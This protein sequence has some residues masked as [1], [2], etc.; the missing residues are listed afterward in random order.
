LVAAWREALSGHS[1]SRIGIAWQGNPAYRGDRQRSFP[2]ECFMPLAKLADVKLFSLQK[3]FGSEQLEQCETPFVTESLGP[4]LNDLAD[5]AGVMKNLD[6]IITPDTAIAH[7]AGA[8]GVPV[9]IALPFTPDWR[10]LRDRT[11]TPWYPTMRLF[12]QS[13][14]GNWNSVFEPMAAELVTLAKKTEVR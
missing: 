5:T 14:P 2:L 12:R 3:G 9:W 7:L 1:G 6:L 4:R 13:A 10:W 8:I 11:E